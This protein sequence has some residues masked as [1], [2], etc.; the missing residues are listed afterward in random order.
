MS[1][2]CLRLTCAVA[3]VAHAVKEHYGP[4]VGSKGVPRCLRLHL[5]RAGSQLPAGL[6]GTQQL[7]ECLSLGLLCSQRVSCPHLAR[8]CESSEMV[9]SVA[10]RE[11]EPKHQSLCCLACLC[12]DG[13]ACCSKL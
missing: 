9:C 1:C 5:R 13:V 3:Q 4:R 11:P 12:R 7:C 10:H 8:A 6:R 2:S